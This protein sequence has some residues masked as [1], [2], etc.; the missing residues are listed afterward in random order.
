MNGTLNGYKDD[1]LQRLY[2]EVYAGV[3][4]IP[5]VTSASVSRYGLLSGDLTGDGITVPGQKDSVH[6]DI[7]YIFPGYFHTMGV[8]LLVGRDVADIRHDIG[9]ARRHRQPRLC[10]KGLRHGCLPSAAHCSST[11]RP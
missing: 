5:G 4:A 10:H 11:T 7:H 1:R 3:A 2:D 6:A 9:A 8:P